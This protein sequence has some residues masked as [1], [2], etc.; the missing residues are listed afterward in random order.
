MQDANPTVFNPKGVYDGKKIFYSPIAYNF[1]NQHEFRVEIRGK[2]WPVR[3]QKVLRAGHPLN[4]EVL[5]RYIQGN[6]TH[7]E[8]VLTVINACNVAIRMEPIQNY[9]FN[10]R[11]FYPGNEIRPIGRGIELWRGYFQSIR[12]GIGKMFINV[13]IATGMFFKSGP[14]IAVCLEIL[15]AP[16]N[17]DPTQWLGR[18][19]NPRAKNELLKSIRNLKVKTERRGQGSQVRPIKEFSDKVADEHTFTDDSGPTTVALST[20]A[21]VP[22]ER[23]IVEPG[24]AMRKQVP[25]DLMSEVLG[26][27][28]MRPEQRLQSIRNG[29]QTLQYGNS[30]YLREFGINVEANPMRINGRLL[31]PP[32]LQYGRNA[33]I[34]PANGQWNMRDKRLYEPATVKG[35]VF[36]IYDKRFRPDAEQN[37]KQGLFEA[38]RDLGITGMPPDPP[39][40][41][42]DPSGSGYSNHLREAAMLHK[43]VKGSFPSLIVV[44][45][46]DFGGDDIYRRVKN[47]GDIMI[48]VATQCLKSSKC[49]KAG[50]AQYWANVCL[51]INVKLGGINVV[52]RAESI[53][54]LVDPANPTL[55]I[56]ADVMHPG[57]GVGGRPSFASVIGSVDSTTSKYIATTRA[58]RPRQ[59][60]IEELEEMV[61]YMITMYMRYRGTVEK[62]EQK[63]PKRIIFYRDGISEGQF[64]E[65]KDVEVQRIKAACRRANI[66]PKLTFIVVGKRHH[67]RFFPANPGDADRSGNA[68]AG[69]VVDREITSP[70]EFDFYLQSH[71]GLL[72]TSRSAHYNVLVDENR[73]TPDNIQQLSFALCHVYARSTRSVSIVPP[74]YYADI[75]CARARHHYDPDSDM[76]FSETASQLSSEAAEAQLAIYQQGFRPLH[77]GQSQMMYF[78]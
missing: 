31:A 70:V 53:R 34:Q 18:N 17:A 50:N 44:I 32:T 2:T 48:G 68:P 28:T 47:A 60:M 64:Q 77:A 72:G 45:L 19:M 65:C 37:C 75:V 11:S 43:N 33:T 27:A 69:L 49:W 67:I 22:L 62:K 76:T 26:F 8:N 73:F 12:P 63:A 1:G 7:D 21:Y 66:N 56:G 58:Q 74:V 15:G 23:C 57:P 16:P 39:V 59:E 29:L 54:V 51:K 38:C 30:P 41:K 35:C 4:P 10:V 78:Q 9:P 42:K 3:M 14:L 36:L 61:H 71:G 6:Q 5:A 24:Q 20:K 40:L 46:P 52:P 25:Q 55:V 13:D